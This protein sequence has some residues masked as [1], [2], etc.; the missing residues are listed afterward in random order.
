MVFESGFFS[1]PKIKH[2]IVLFIGRA[3]GRFQPDRSAYP[4]RMTARNGHN[5]GCYKEV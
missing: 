5:G 3:S 1:I 2:D 4:A